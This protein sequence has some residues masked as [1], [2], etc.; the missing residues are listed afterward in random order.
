MSV[1][2]NREPNVLEAS[3]RSRA[4]TSTVELTRLQNAIDGQVIAPGDTGYEQARKI[5]WGGFDQRPAAIV[6][7]AGAAG[8]AQIVRLAAETGLELAVRGGGHSSAGHGLSDGGIV[9]DL[10]RLTEI[11]ID[12]HDC[13]AWA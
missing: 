6:R 2:L 7:P 8:V 3:G 4:G 5:F 11:D 13:T 10:S 12:T 1:R 9:L